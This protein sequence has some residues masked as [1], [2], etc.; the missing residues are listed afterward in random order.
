[1]LLWSRIDASGSESTATL[2]HLGVAGVVAATDTEVDEITAESPLD[3]KVSMVMSL[4]G[5]QEQA[6]RIPAA[7]SRSVSSASSFSAGSV[8]V[9]SMIRTLH[10][11]QVPF[12][13]QEHRTR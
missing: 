12:P 7:S 6:R 3:A 9:P 8:T 4:K 11:P 13:P 10:L 2:M 5:L 1:M